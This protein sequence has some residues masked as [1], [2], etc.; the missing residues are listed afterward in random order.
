M[1]APFTGG[2]MCGKV[3]YRVDAE[4]MMFAF[5]HCRECRYVSGGEPASVVVVP[6][7]AFHIT[8]GEVRNYRSQAKS[9]NFVTRKFCPDCGTPLFS[10][11]EA[12]PAIW[13]VKAGSMDDDSWLT[14]ALTV[15][16]DTAAPWAHR[17]AGLPEFP[18]NPPG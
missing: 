9:G 16:T 3:R 4:P 11:V 15:W 13:V 17:P 18:E 7:E 14:P 12:M 6:R 5:C 8:A 1:V 10:D 2:C